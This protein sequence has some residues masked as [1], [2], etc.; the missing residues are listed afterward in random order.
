MSPSFVPSH[1]YEKKVVARPMSASATSPRASAVSA[2]VS[3]SE[4]PVERVSAHTL[5]SKPSF[6]IRSPISMLSAPRAR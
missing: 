1:E 5:H 6:L 2:S 3:M 4:S